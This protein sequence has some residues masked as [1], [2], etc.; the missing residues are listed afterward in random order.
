MLTNDGTISGYAEG[1]DSQEAI[2]DKLTDIETD[3]G[4]IGTAGA[5]L[6]DLGGM[7]TGMKA[8]VNVEVDTA[9]N[10]A[11]PGTPTADSINER[12]KAIDDLTQASGAGDL[13]AILTDTGTTIPATI[14]TA[15][16]D[17]DTI[18]AFWNVF[19]L[20]AGTIGAV[21]NDTTHLHLTGLAYGDDE[22]NDYILIIYDNSTTRYH[23]VWITDW[24]NASAL[25]TVE[26]MGFTPEDSV[27]TYWVFA[28]KKHPTIAT[29]DSKMD[30]AQAD[31]DTIT[32]TNG[33][34]IDDNAITS[35]KYDESTAFPIGSADTG[36]TQ[37]ARV[38]ADSDTLE[39]LS[40]QI[41]LLAD[42][43]TEPMLNT[44]VGA[45][46]T[47]ATVFTLTTGPAGD[48]ALNDATIC[49]MDN[50]ASDMP[51]WRTIVDYAVTG[52][53]TIFTV[54]LDRALSFTPEASTDEV[55]ISGKTRNNNV[56]GGSANTYRVTDDGLVG[57]NPIQDVHCWVTIDSGGN[58]IVASGDTDASGDVT[59]YLDAGK[60]YYVWK[61]KA[62]Y[63]FE[64][65]PETVTAA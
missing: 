44:T 12:V 53:G 31:L 65:Q 13:A 11:I 33:V 30:T 7:S 19:I 58:T 29:I 26:T 45:T 27:D 24:D 20:T 64:S 10:T 3:T 14:T 15:Q 21:G 54:T 23:S 17:L 56:A 6:T 42:A 63:T 36:S 59:F 32:G 51:E 35:A 38:G 2:R 57:G 8:E 52:A 25:A 43:L 41:D 48:D 37:I 22:L 49:V 16:T 5:G 28:L 46:V 47:S 34:V 1:T 60:T 4:E 62:G 40:D 18:T 9:L 50:S 61:H 39:T 55:I